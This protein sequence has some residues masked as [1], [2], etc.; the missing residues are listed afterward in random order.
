MEGAPS[1]PL[2]REQKAKLLSTCIEPLGDL[3]AGEGRPR[4]MAARCRKRTTRRDKAR[5]CPCSPRG[6][7]H[8]SLS[9][10]DPRRFVKM[11]AT[12][13]KVHLEPMPRRAHGRSGPSPHHPHV[14]HAE[15]PGVPG[16]RRLRGD[17]AIRKSLAAHRPS[18][19]TS[20]PKTK[21]RWHAVHDMYSSPRL[22]DASKPGSPGFY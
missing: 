15:R 3:G 1:D 2:P 21:P 17:S 6:T 12:P 16:C 11:M 22:D 20:L 10:L 4:Q 5:A 8:A 19:K 13:S 18:R 14:T 9:T 7:C